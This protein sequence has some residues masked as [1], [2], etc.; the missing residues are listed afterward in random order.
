M[1]PNIMP[2][3]DEKIKN[4]FDY[5]TLVFA[6]EAAIRQNIKLQFSQSSLSKNFQFFQTHRGRKYPV[7]EW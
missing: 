1:T 6:S 5:C 2:L 4:S 7:I 3:S